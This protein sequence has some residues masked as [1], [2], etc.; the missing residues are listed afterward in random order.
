MAHIEVPAIE[1]DGGGLDLEVT[2]KVTSE[3]HSLSDCIVMC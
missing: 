2:G 3:N 1:M